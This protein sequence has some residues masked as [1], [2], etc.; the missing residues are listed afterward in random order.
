MFL[1]VSTAL[2]SKANICHWKYNLSALSALTFHF[3]TAPRLNTSSVVRVVLQP[4]SV[5]VECS[6]QCF[7]PACA[8]AWAVKGTGDCIGRLFGGLAPGTK[9]SFTG[10]PTTQQGGAGHKRWQAAGYQIAAQDQILAQQN[11]VNPHFCIVTSC[12]LLVFFNNVST[13]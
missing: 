7:G 3:E 4:K 10:R 5:G 8:R 2:L 6:Q 1:L 11:S 12:L 13:P 9:T